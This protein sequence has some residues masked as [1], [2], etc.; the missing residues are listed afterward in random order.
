MRQ[1][2][3]TGVL[4]SMTISSSSTWCG[5]RSGTSTFSSDIALLLV[6]PRPAAEI[7]AVEDAASLV[8]SAVGCRFNALETCVIFLGDNGCAFGCALALVHR[9]VFGLGSRTLFDA[10]SAIQSISARF[11]LAAIVRVVFTVGFAVAFSAP[12]FLDRPAARRV[13]FAAR[14]G[15]TSTSSVVA[16]ST[17]S[18]V[19]TAAALRARVAFGFTDSSAFFVVAV[20][21]RSGFFR[22]ALLRSGSAISAEGSICAVRRVD[23][24]L[25]ER[26]PLL[27]RPSTTDGAIRALHVRL[28]LMMLFGK[29]RHVSADVAG[30]T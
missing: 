7:E 12:S 17:A 8:F 24:I 29:Q 22:K 6:S 25:V 11:V 23:T 19:P 27:I 3:F 4:C 28:G 26:Y 21:L 2:Y 30:P 9:V 20:A 14:G 10:S 5:G 16:V 18:D 15:A 13:D 1:A